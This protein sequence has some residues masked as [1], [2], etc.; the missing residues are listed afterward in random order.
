MYIVKLNILGYTRAMISKQLQQQLSLLIIRSNM[1][2]KYA[3]V[4]TAE[5]NNLTMMQA[6]ILCL[7]DPGQTVPMKSLSTFMSCDP[8]NVTSMIEQLVAEGHVVRKEAVHDRRIKE[9]SLT[10]KGLELRDTFLDLTI[11]TRL[12]NLEVLNETE[13]QQLITILEKA[14]TVSVAAGV[15]SPAV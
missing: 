12:P 14:T 13:T 9:L 11:S 5:A 1:K 4:E 3:I 2:G 6:L 7:L 8:S 15:S 10:E